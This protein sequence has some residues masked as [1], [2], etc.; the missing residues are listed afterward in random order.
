MHAF[1]EQIDQNN[2]HVNA[3]VAMVPRA[4]LLAQADA[5]DDQ[6]RQGIYL[7][8]LH[9]IPMAPKDIPPVKGMLTTCGSTL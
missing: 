3:I 4:T 2:P 8:P 9:G 1:L 5:R 7:G 6:L